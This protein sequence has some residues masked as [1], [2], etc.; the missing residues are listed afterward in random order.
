MDPDTDI[1]LDE[2]EDEDLEDQLDDGGGDPVA[3]DELPDELLSEEERTAKA[4]RIKDKAADEERKRRQGEDDR[5]KNVITEA[6]AGVRSAPEHR[7]P[8]RQAPAK[9]IRLTADQRAALNQKILEDPEGLVKLY[10]S[11][12][13][14]AYQR[15]MTDFRQGTAPAAS[16][17]GESVAERFATR[18]LREDT[19]GRQIEPFFNE[20]LEGYDLSSLAAMSQ[21]ERKRSLEDLWDVAAGRMVRKKGKVRTQVSPGV[22]RGAG[23][24]GRMQRRRQ[25]YKMSDAEKAQMMASAVTPEG[26]DRMRRAILEIENG[27]ITDPAIARMVDDSVRFTENTR[28]AI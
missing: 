9:P 26:K 19:L 12:E 1:D 21:D 13:E 2:D 27:V 14:R 5:L 25:K 23:G 4:Q 7:E 11:A 8:D 15:A 10:E 18:M 16:I 6:F 28:A 3:D 22:A 17:L 24:S 20:L